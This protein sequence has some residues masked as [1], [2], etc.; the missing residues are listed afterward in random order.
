M[1]SIPIEEL[2]QEMDWY[3][4]GKLPELQTEHALGILKA[5]EKYRE[6]IQA[7]EQAAQLLREC[8]AEGTTEAEEAGPDEYY[9]TELVCR[10]CKT[11]WMC[12][13][14]NGLRFYRYCPGCGREVSVVI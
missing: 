8:A 2:I 3:R 6:T 9:G 13:D 14:E 5:L 1:K 11:H 4:S 12:F 7:V 10:K